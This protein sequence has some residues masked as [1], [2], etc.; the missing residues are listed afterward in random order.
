[1]NYTTNLWWNWRWF[2]IVL[3][4]LPG[5]PGNLVLPHIQNS[6]RHRA[7]PR[8]YGLH[9]HLK[10]VNARFFWLV[11]KQLVGEALYIYIS[12]SFSPMPNRQSKATI[13]EVGNHRFFWCNSLPQPSDLFIIIVSQFPSDIPLPAT[14]TSTSRWLA[15]TIHCYAW[16]CLIYDAY[17]LIY[18]E[19]NCV[20]WF[21]MI[22]ILQPPFWMIHLYRFIYIYNIP[23]L[24]LITPCRWCFEARCFPC[25]Y[26]PLFSGLGISGSA[27]REALETG[28]VG[29]LETWGKLVQQ[30]LR[31]I[32]IPGKFKQWL[33]MSCYVMNLNSGFLGYIIPI[34]LDNST[35]NSS[36]GIDHL[37]V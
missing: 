16:P 7:F 35:V 28:W 26:C 21:L 5:K 10:L 14:L 23:C 20:T 31:K 27:R 30:S 22:M 37:G 25:Y 18:D 29:A 8:G 3:P 12:I 2:T 11:N 17:D 33:V 24:M 32:Q 34:I 19:C 1:M 4:T 13:L 6:P 9:R 36:M 15:L